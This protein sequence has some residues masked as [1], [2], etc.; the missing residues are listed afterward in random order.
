MSY[1]SVKLL[2]VHLDDLLDASGT[3]RF[4]GGVDRILL[5]VCASHVHVGS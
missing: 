3:G 4:E 2:R 5:V 1:L